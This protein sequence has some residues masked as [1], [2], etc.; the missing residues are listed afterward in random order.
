MNARRCTAARA[1]ILAA[2]FLNVLSLNVFFG[3]ARLLAD[4]GG[5]TPRLA[6]VSRAGP[7]QRLAGNGPYEGNG[8]RPARRCCGNTANA[9]RGIQGSRS[10]KG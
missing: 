8:P 7:Q 3:A 5:G 9:A 4:D 2:L 1:A 10:P 6:R